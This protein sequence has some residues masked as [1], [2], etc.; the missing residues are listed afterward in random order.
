MVTRWYLLLS[1]WGLSLT[2]LASGPRIMVA[3][4]WTRVKANCKIGTTNQKLPPVT[5]ILTLVTKKL[6][7]V[8]KTNFLSRL[9]L[10]Y[11]RQPPA[12]VKQMS[13]EL[14]VVLY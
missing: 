2:R 14:R 1:K 12:P 5:K 6:P 7:P 9:L 13:I 10:P 8:T 11:L 4:N 3:Y